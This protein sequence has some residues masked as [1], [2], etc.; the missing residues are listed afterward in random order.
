MLGNKPESIDE[1]VDGITPEIHQKLKSAVELGKW[2]SGE[3]LSEEQKAYCMQAIIAYEHRHVPI[4]QRTG[5]MNPRAMA[6]SN[7]TKKEG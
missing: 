7:C 1:L 6:G 2:E 3:A 5:F 4:E